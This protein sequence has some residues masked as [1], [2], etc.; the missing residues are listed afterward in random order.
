MFFALVSEP[1]AKHSWA[2][3]QSWQKIWVKRGATERNRLI[4]VIFSEGQKFS[5]TMPK[6]KFLSYEPAR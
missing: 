3:E 4:A 5:A 1:E 2:N 6:A